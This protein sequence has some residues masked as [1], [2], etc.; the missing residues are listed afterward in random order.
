M[1]TI[2]PAR[3]RETYRL[4]AAQLRKMAQRAETTGRKVNGY[5]AEQLNER[6]FKM[7]L[8]AVI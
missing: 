1:Q 4:N 3:V 8:L 7:A 6:A 5:T 2:N